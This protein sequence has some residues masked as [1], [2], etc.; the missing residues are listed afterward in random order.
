MEVSEKELQET[1]M[2]VIG[3]SQDNGLTFGVSKCAEVVYKRRKIIK[4]EGLQVDNS[5]AESL[6]PEAVEYYK[7]LGIEEGN[8]QLS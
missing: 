7:F 8:G 3:I 1:N 2:I 6:N 4:G 5:K